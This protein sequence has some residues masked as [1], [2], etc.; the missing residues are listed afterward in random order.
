MAPEAAFKF[1]T[2]MIAKPGE[3]MSERMPDNELDQI[4]A[5]A[6]KAQTLDLGLRR[7]TDTV[8]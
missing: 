7:L 1:A 8:L 6:A 2:M 4:A 5:V 3:L